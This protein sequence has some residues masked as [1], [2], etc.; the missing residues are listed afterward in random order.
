MPDDAVITPIPINEDISSLSAILLNDDYYYF[1]RD[2]VRRI[3]D[4]PIL[5][6]LHI[7]PFKAKAWLDL[8]ERRG[9]GESVDSGD[10]NKHRRDIYR[11][12]DMVTS[13]YKFNLP[14]TIAQDMRVFLAAAQ[15]LLNNTPRKAREAEMNRIEKIKTFFGL[16]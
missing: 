10:I 1:L 8:S 9:K 11:L 12:S 15:E 6:E 13:G 7:I 5:D 14:E 4:F 16:N 3:D 2:G